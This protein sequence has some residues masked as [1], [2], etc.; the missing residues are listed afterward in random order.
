MTLLEQI[1]TMP[2]KLIIFDLDGTLIDSVPDLALSVDE[3]LNDLGREKA[4]QDKVRHWVG[5]GAAMLVKRALADHMTPTE[6]DDALFQQAHQLF[7]KHYQQISGLKSR[8]YPDVS[9]T[10]KILRDKYP[11]L[12]IVTN[13]PQQFTPS[14]L[15][16]HDLPGF[17]LVL[18]GDSLAEKKPH[19]APL[20]HCVEHFGCSA[21]ESIMVGD[22]VSD[23]KAAQAAGI[24]VVC[25]NYGYNQGEDLSSYHPDALIERFE[26]LL[27]KA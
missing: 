25:V 18:C 14:I 8:L 21:N 3:M 11:Y 2:P 19:P 27:G 9:T 5:N 7:L 22:S 24:P 4:G 13:K 17:D 12:A 20:L 16:S 15:N 10:L 6:I 23:I 26:A 1:S